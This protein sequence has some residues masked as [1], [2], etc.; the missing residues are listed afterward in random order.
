MQRVRKMQHIIFLLFRKANRESLYYLK[1]FWIVVLQVQLF[2]L[3]CIVVLYSL[4]IWVDMKCFELV[5]AHWSSLQPFI[6]LCWPT[7]PA[8]FADW[9]NL[10]IGRDYCSVN[11]YGG[12][13]FASF[14]RRSEALCFDAHTIYQCCN[15]K[16]YC[17]LTKQK[18]QALTY[19]INFHWR[20]EHV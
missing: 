11:K 19:R 18:T 8:C 17:S 2:G 6:F 7:L 15:K 20:W 13:K 9:I 10:K 4:R 5:W 1:M 16:K 3:C 12:V 14:T